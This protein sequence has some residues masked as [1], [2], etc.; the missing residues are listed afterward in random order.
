MW[1]DLM[2]GDLHTCTSPCKPPVASAA[3]S[4]PAEGALGEEEGPP[5]L[6]EG[7]ATLL[8]EETLGDRHTCTGAPS[9]LLSATGMAETETPTACMT[10]STR[11]SVSSCSRAEDGKAAAAPSSFA[12]DSELDRFLLPFTALEEGWGLEKPSNFRACCIGENKWRGWF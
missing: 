10:S 12:N 7:V 3:G 6:S 5:P 4:V 2:C 8:G 11:S 9:W 1:G